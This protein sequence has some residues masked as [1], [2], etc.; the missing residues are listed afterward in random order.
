MHLQPILK[1]VLNREIGS[2]TK[3][4]SRSPTD[5]PLLGKTANKFL[6]QQGIGAHLGV[7]MLCFRESSHSIIIEKK[8]RESFNGESYK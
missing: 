2:L 8:Y 3:K 1:M 6:W 4:V 5:C 7:I